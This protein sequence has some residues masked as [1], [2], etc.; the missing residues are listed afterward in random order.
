MPSRDSKWTPA[1]ILS[2]LAL[3]SFLTRTFIDYRFV[4]LELGLDRDALASTTLIN[5]VLFGAWIWAIVAASHGGR[6]G[7]YAL[8]GFSLLLV[9]FGVAT[10][11]SLCPSPCRTFWPVGE[12]AIWSN[13]VIGV[14]A[15][16][17]LG[18]QLFGRSGRD[19]GE[20]EVG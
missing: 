3:L 9:A 4:Y 17:L 18:R 20:P 2:L 12:I 1:L 13:L 16:A 14:P 19:R 15:A 6:G 5:L 8:L 11:V 10:L 7:L